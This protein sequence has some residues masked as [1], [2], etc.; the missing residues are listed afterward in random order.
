[1]IE[2]L[3]TICFDLDGTLLDV[4]EKY[5]RL[6]SRIANDLK[7][8]PLRESAFW[9]LKRQK[10]SLEELLPDWGESARDEYHDF[11]QANIESPTYTRHDRL[12]PG[13]EEVLTTLL[14]SYSL[15]L[16][17][18]RRERPELRRQL[19]RLG[20]GRY[21]RY[22]I[23]TGDTPAMTTKAELARRWVV[24]QP[25]A[26]LLLVGDTEEDIKCARVIGAAAIGVL[27]GLR[28][29]KM[30][31]THCPDE[32]IDSVRE[33]PGLMQR[34]T[35]LGASTPSFQMATPRR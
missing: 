30:L 15:V 33:L 23:V 26:P 25:S 14:Q 5:Y 32:I 6:H 21:F 34:R 18:A 31:Q 11:W 7:Y 24:H 35:M 19:L 29:R 16:I 17:T 27:T 3:N 28:N 4:R 20:M 8:R 10:C 13:A 12:L 1:M 9:A 22:L 2:K